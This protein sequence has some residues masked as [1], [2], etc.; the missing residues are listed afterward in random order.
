[1]SGE[2]AATETKKDSEDS[3]TSPANKL[4]NLGGEMETL[5]IEALAQDFVNF[6]EDKEKK[7]SLS[8]FNVEFQPSSGEQLK[9]KDN[10]QIG[11]IVVSNDNQKLGLP[12]NTPLLI[13][14]SNSVEAAKIDSTKLTDSNKQLIKEIQQEHFINFLT[15]Q[16][17]KAS[18]NIGSD[19]NSQPITIQAIGFNLDELSQLVKKI[20]EPG[21][22]NILQNIKIELP[23]IAECKCTPEE[24]KQMKEQIDSL[25]P[26]TQKASFGATDQKPPGQSS[27]AQVPQADAN[28]PATPATHKP[29]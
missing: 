27:D 12:A 18:K 7:K 24:Y 17:N 9:D 6:Y 23:N 21:N 4:A 25:N 22:N 29:S 11:Q 5:D 26:S 1:M 19:G 2:A 28:N 16:A 13:F 10:K 14:S 3:S 20:Q 8:N 15:L